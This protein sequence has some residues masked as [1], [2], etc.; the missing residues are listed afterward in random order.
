MRCASVAGYCLGPLGLGLRCASI[1][2]YCMGRLWVQT[3]LHMVW[4]YIYIYVYMYVYIYIYIF[5]YLSQKDMKTT[6]RI[7]PRVH[8]GHGKVVGSNLFAYGMAKYKYIYIFIYTYMYIYICF[9]IH[10]YIYLYLL[11]YLS[12]KYMKTTDRII[13]RVHIGFL[14]F[15]AF[16]VNMFHKYIYIYIF[17]TI[18]LAN[19]YAA[20]SGPVPRSL[21]YLWDRQWWKQLMWCSIALWH[22]LSYASYVTL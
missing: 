3:F 13:P 12:H 17:I 15:S 4:I 10:I 14:C 16:F 19:V 18:S 21:T 6:N 22:T 1:A 8:I 5:I 20:F 11:I 7:S 2:G 9:Y